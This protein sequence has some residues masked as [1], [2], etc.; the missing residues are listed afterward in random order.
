MAGQIDNSQEGG[1]LAFAVLFG[2]ANPSQ[3]RKL[4]T[5]A[6]W[7]PHG[8]VNVWP[9][10]ARYN[11]E[12]PGRHNV[13]VWPMVHSMFGHAA[14]LG[15]R[16]DLFGRAVADL[17]NLV[18]GTDNHFYELYN[19]ITGARD[20]GWQ[21]NRHWTSQPDQTWSATG[22]LRMIYSGLFGLTFTPDE[23]TI[24]PTLP[25]G[26]GPVSLRCLRYRDMTLDIELSGA[27]NQVRSSTVDGRPGRPRIRADGHGAHTI[28]I[29]LGDDHGHS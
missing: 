20:G 7:Q 18:T 29:R 2:V 11:D 9:H 15:G 14:A 13:M 26:W 1:G 16:V 5:N 21:V 19:S 24:A 28:S 17:A 8:I 10:F 6:H 27:G 3:V 23:L 4:L 22:Y 25:Q 12:M